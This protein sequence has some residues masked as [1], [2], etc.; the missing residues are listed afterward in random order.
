MLGLHA[1]WIIKLIATFTLLYKALV[2]LWNTPHQSAWSPHLSKDIKAL[3]SVQRRAS[4]IALKQKRGEM[5]YL[6]RCVLLKWNTFEKRR[7][8]LSLIK[9]YKTVFGLNG[10]NFDEVFEYKKSRKTRSNHKYS[11]YT[12]ISRVNSYIS[13]LFL[14]HSLMYILY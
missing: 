2:R 3:E 14:S 9:C 6:D 8:Y 1:C 5:S 11:L 7:E 13:I 4:R 12:K 10:I